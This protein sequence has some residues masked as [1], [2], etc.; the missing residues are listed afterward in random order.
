MTNKLN[1]KHIKI[2]MNRVF[3]FIKN[4]IPKISSTEFIALRSGTSSIDRDILKGKLTYP[5]TPITTN[6]FP[7]EKLDE[8]LKTYDGSR[9]Y[10]ND[11]QNIQNIQYIHIV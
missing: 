8:L 1:I 7:N 9:I 2:N 3:S 5:K 6:K 10:P 4:K 11:N